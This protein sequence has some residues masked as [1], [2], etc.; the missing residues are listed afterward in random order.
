MT[1]P[2]SPKKTPHFESPQVFVG[3][4]GWVTS[5]GLSPN[6][7]PQV[8]SPALFSN[9]PDTHRLRCRVFSA[10]FLSL[11]PGQQVMQKGSQAKGFGGLPT[12]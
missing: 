12:P 6:K 1:I 8:D 11:G 5:Q 7:T 9:L 4:F 10:A 2:R 3:D